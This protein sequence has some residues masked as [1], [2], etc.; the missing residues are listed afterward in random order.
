MLDVELAAGVA[1][2][3]VVG[4]GLVIKES[5]E[6]HGA[7][8]K[9]AFAQGVLYGLAVHVSMMQH[10]FDRDLI[11]SLVEERLKFDAVATEGVC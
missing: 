9:D 5:H 8:D 10:V 2:E 1:K 7:G 6:K 11:L 3:I 4:V